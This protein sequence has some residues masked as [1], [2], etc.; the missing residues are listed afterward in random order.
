MAEKKFLV[1]LNL[2]KNELKQAVVENQG[3]APENP[4]DG[5]IYYNTASGTKGVNVYKTNA[6][7]RLLDEDDV[8]GYVPTTRKINGK[9]LSSDVT[10]Y[11]TDIAM[12]SSD[13]TTV[14]AA[15]ED[16]VVKNTAITAATKCKITY[17]AK[18]LVTAGADLQASDIPDLASN[19]VTAMTGYTKASSVAAIATTDSLNTAIG[20][21][22][23]GIDG[24]VDANAAITGNTKCKITYD[25][26][27][28]VTNG[29]DLQVSDIP[30]LGTSK[31]TTLDGYSKGSSSA[32]LNTTDSLNQAL[33]KLE[34][35]VDTKVT[36]NSAITASTT[37]K[38]VIT[39]D[40]KGLVTGG[41]EIA[42]DS[43]STN[44][45]GFDTSTHKISAKVDTTVTASSTKLVTSGAVS[46]AIGTALTGAMKYQGT[47]TATS[48]TDYSSIALP[49]SKGYMYAVSGSAT[50]GG[51]EWNSGDYLVINKDIAAGG[52]ITSADVDKIDNTE[53]SDLVRLSAT[54][55]LTNK[56]IDADDNTISDLTTSNLKSGVLQTTI[57]AAASAT[58]TAIASEKAIRTE[59]DLKAPLASPAL[60]GTPTAPTAATGTNTTQV[61]TTAF[62]Q[63]AIANSSLTLASNNTALTQS[64]GVCTWTI[65]NT[66]NNADVICS[67]REVSSGEEVY[68]NITYTASTI[69]IKINSSSNIAAGTYRAVIIGQKINS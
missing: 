20:K 55:T 57:R 15:I 47:W 18:G 34:N 63:D 36:A 5:Q 12:S 50:I 31:V 52:T 9:A 6:W 17:D 28:L 19:K 69:T 11:G 13:S 60:T 32:A 1:D 14:K 21:L 3:L 29:A 59:L 8:T 27:G 44:Y 16:K 48:Q 25:S 66:L 10:L 64:G 68:C 42:I 58:D 62:V 35:Q 23:K 38:T 33:S 49:V 61:A 46:S 67:V 39:Y 51:V 26:K 41:S 4:K 54:Q 40:A 24:K 65:T 45:L 56:T 30:S 22:E 37:G 7:K 43:G 53:S 2:N